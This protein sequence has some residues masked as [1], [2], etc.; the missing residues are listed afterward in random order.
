INIPPPPMYTSAQKSS[1]LHIDIST[2]PSIHNYELS[3]HQ[4]SDVALSSS[5]S[6]Y[7]PK[8]RHRHISVGSYYDNKTTTVAIHPNHTLYIVG[9]APVSPL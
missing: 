8:I 9:S 5:P 6:S 4:Y 3:T 7:T 1:S 2:Y